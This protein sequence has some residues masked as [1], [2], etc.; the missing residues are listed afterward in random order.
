[1]KITCDLIRD[2][3]PLY[4]DG[5]C[6]DESKE[7][8][9]E[10]LKS[11]ESCKEELRF[12]DAPLENTHIAVEDEKV[13]KASSTAWKKRKNRSF[14]IGC[15]AALLVVAL[16]I[17]SY[18]AVHWFSTADENNIEAL[19]QQA[20]DYFDEVVFDVLEVEQR[21]NY[22]AMLYTSESGNLGMCVFD[23]DSLF[24]NRWKANGG[25]KSFSQG[26]IVSWN[27]GSSDREAVL[28]FC[29]ANIPEKA[30]WY[31]FQNSDITY[32]CPIKN[33]EVLDVFVIQ[34]SNNINGYP[35]LL[36][37]DKQEIE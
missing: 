20:A 26:E 19:A 24:N 2:L 30:M 6:S 11:C 5:V 23:R 1:M 7:L 8:V 25:K 15:V 16:A 33:G 13:I 10:H 18:V 36:D 31:T 17:G 9:N 37:S 12:M 22:L 4:R 32:T 14:I 35:V 21:G 3:L 27:F 28:I 34:D 29:G